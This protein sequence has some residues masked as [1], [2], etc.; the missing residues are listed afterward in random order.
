MCSYPW[1]NRDNCC[2]WTR[3]N[4]NI[5]EAARL[6]K[7]SKMPSHPGGFEFQGFGKSLNQT[8]TPSA[9][10]RSICRFGSCETTRYRNSSNGFPGLDKQIPLPTREARVT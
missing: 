8:S 7:A 10:P 9:G 1:Q 6:D 2:E 3:M 4:A 5:G